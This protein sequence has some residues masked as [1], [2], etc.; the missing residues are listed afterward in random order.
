MDQFL[1]KTSRNTNTD[2][3]IGKD[4]EFSFATLLKHKRGKQGNVGIFCSKKDPAKQ[5]LFKVSRGVDYIVEHED[6]ITSDVNLLTPFCPFY[7]KKY[8]L[9]SMTVYPA[10][11][12]TNPFDKFVHD[13]EDDDDSSSDSDTEDSSSGSTAVSPPPASSPKKTTHTG[14]EKNVLFLEYLENACKLSTVI[15][16]GSKADINNI[17]A[18]IKQ[19]MIAILIGKSN[20][21]MTHYDMHSDNIMVQKC[22]KNA[23]ILYIHDETTSYCVPTLGY[24]PIVIDFGFSYSRSIDGNMSY[25]GLGHTDIGF[26]SNQY[27]DIA[28][29][30]LFLVSV[31]DELKEEREGQ[32]DARKLRR[33]VRNIFNKLPLD[34]ETGWDDLRED[35]AAL[36]VVTDVIRENILV[37]EEYNSM[38]NNDKDNFNSIF[39]EYDYDCFEIIQGLTKVPFSASENFSLDKLIKSYVVFVREFKHIERNIRGSYYLLYILKVIVNAAR[40]IQDRF[41]LHATAINDDQRQSAIKEFYIEINEKVSK[42]VSFFTP[43]GIHYEKLLCSLFILAEQVGALLN[44]VIETKTE[45]KASIIKTLPMSNIEHMFECIDVNIPN[46][47]EFN[48]NSEVYVI[49]NIYKT[50]T[51]YEHPLKPAEIDLLN[52]APYEEDDNIYCGKYATHQAQLLRSIISACSQEAMTNHHPASSSQDAVMVDPSTRSENEKTL[53][54]EPDM[55]ESTSQS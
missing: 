16:R 1:K 13:E 48:E 27:D 8:G 53:Q 5:V 22:S 12:D 23:V 51:K 45:C 6:I 49:D 2:D 9:K 52:Q 50:F 32:Q 29:S 18:L 44:K 3:F 35:R 47:Y 20:V 21:R 40:N 38:L 55:L 37:S 36:D 33:I 30:K 10:N 11:E 43:K 42:V 26:T 17:M 24:Y 25:S 28:D 34:W 14:I 31:S 15:R 4:D 19:V 41:L 7:P 54:E 46:T 39:S